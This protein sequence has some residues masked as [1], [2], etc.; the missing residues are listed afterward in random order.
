MTPL[1]VFV[2]HAAFDAAILADQETSSD[3]NLEFSLLI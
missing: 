1:A 2:I 3:A